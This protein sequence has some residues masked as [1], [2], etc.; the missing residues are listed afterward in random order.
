MRHLRLSRNLVRSLG[1]VI[2]TLC[3]IPRGAPG[4]QHEIV[5]VDFNQEKDGVPRGWELHEKAGKADIALVN[6]GKDQVLRLRSQASSF[7]L[8]TEVDIDL[9]QTPVIQ[10][11]WKVTELPQRGDFRNNARDDQA[12][13]LYVLF[14]PDVLRTEVIA[15]IWDSTAPKGTTAE[16]TFP[17]VYPVLRMRAVVVESGEANTGKWMTVTRN[18][19]EDYKKLFGGDPDRISGIRIQI[20]S[21]HTKS[22]AECYWRYVK[23]KGQS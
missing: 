13:Q 8:Q 1:L 6:D 9:K 7:A 3:F 14:S 5:V 17:P 22:Q 21:Q 11:Q 18:V 15:Y 16:P 10:W 2:L 19:V 12:A 20:N 4:A 23:V